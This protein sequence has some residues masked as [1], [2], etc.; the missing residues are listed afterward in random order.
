MKKGLFTLNVKDKEAGFPRGYDSR[1]TDITYPSL[2]AYADRIG[3]TFNV[4]E[5]RKFPTWPVLFER[6]QLCEIAKDYDWIVYIDGDALVHPETID[7]TE[8][9]AKDTVAHNGSDFAN[10]RWDYDRFFRRDGRNIG[11]CHW[12]G[13]ASDWCREFWEPPK[14]ITLAECLRRIHPTVVELEAGITKEHLIDDFLISRNIAKYGLKFTTL[15]DLQARLGLGNANFFWHTYTE[16]VEVKVKQLQ[17]VAD[18]WAAGEHHKNH[19][20]KFD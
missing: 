9:L 7:Y 1:I 13:I 10:V 2:K 19:T 15:R 11:S 14:D 17:L 3:A 6:L 20:P 8:F 16:P 18:A 5:K 4:I 12:L